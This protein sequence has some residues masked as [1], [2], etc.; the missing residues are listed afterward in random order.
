MNCPACGAP[1]A[2]KPDTEGYK[3]DYCHTV[4][5]PGE[6]DDGVKMGVQSGAQAGN[7]AADDAGLQDGVQIDVQDSAASANAGL[8]PSAGLGQSLAC[9]LCSLPLVQASIAKI[10]VL[11]CNQCQGLLLPMPVLQPIL[12][13]LRGGAQSAAVQTPPDAGDI[14]RALRCPKCNQR[15]DTH[16]YAGPG[17]V[18]VDSCD[19]CDLLWLDRGELTRIAHAPDESSVEESSWA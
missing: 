11:F 12:E 16:Y 4:F 3:C 15:M 19:N 10:P 17:N 9:P 1:I 7:Q 5:Y 13:E 18:I 8:A 14:K 6:Q 2:L